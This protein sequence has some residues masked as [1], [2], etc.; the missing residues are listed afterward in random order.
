MLF[1]GVLFAMVC[2][3]SACQ[4]QTIEAGPLRGG[5][6]AAQAGNGAVEGRDYSVWERKRFYDDQGYVQAVEAFSVLVP[7]GWEAKGGVAWKN[8]FQCAGETYAPYLTVSSRDGAIQFRALPMQA[9]G[10]ATS[11]E[12]RQNLEMARQYGG[13]AV[14]PPM[15]AEQYLRQVLAPRELGNPTVESVEANGEVVQQMMAKSEKY[16]ATAAAMGI[17]L[18]FRA[19]AVMARLRWPD[20]TQGMAT[21]T[22]LHGRSAMQNP[23]TGG[24]QESFTSVAAERSV[25]RFPAERRQEAER[26]LATLRSN[27]RTNPE[28]ERAVE[29]FSQRMRA[30]RN[31]N[32]EQV[33]AQLEANRQ[34]MIAGHQQ[35]MA[36][37]ARQGAANTAAFQD[38]MK[39]MDQTQ[40]AWE[41]RQSASDRMHSSF[42]QAIRGVE[43]WT[44]AGGPVELSAGYEK[45]WTRGDGAYILS[46]KPGF[47]PAAVLQDPEWKPLKRVP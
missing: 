38:R 26:F 32:H 23:Y 11:P 25:L 17:P 46:N 8:P 16:R 19:A 24:M 7:R 40:R 9:W 6:K 27:Y 36:D 35:R 14:A 43:T 4:A 41:A 20:G 33:M 5:A 3:L 44:G 12:Q 13:C 22:L 29:E 45:A 2:G 37:I 30:W 1:A 28:W 34:R 47:D 42:V 18:E 21:A 39:T 15:S 10:W 31:Q